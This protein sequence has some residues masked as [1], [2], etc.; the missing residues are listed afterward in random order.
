VKRLLGYAKHLPDFSW[1][2][3]VLTRE[4][5]G[6]HEAD[7]SWG[8]SWEPH[9]ERDGTCSI[10]RVPW[11]PPPPRPRRRRPA[12]AASLP[13]TAPP[14]DGTA[15]PADGTA[16]PADDAAPHA[17]FPAR[18]AAKLE[19]MR[20]M[21]FEGYPDGFTGWVGPAVEAGVRVA[22]EHGV[23]LIMSYCPPESNHLV[24]RR[25]A[26]RLGVPWVAFF[27]DLWGFL[28][29][30]LPAHSLEGLFR[31][32]WHRW[33]LAPA[34]ACAAVSPAMVD[35]LERAYS[36]PTRLIHTGFDPEEFPAQTTPAQPRDRLLISHVGSI[37]PGDQ[38]PD[39]LFDGLDRLLRAH[40]EIA[41][42]LEVR[43][44]GSKCDDRLRTLLAGRPAARVCTVRPGVDSASAIRLVRESH[45]LLAFTCTA[46][47]DRFGTLSFPTKIFEAFGARR[48]ILAI[49]PTA[50]GSM[51]C[52]RTPAATRAPATPPTSPLASSTGSPPGAATAAC[53]TTPIRTRSRST[54]A[55]ARSPTSPDS[56]IPCADPEPTE[57]ERSSPRMTGSHP[58]RPPQ[59]TPPTLALLRA[60]VHDD[61][62][63]IRAALADPATDL[64]AFL[65][66]AHRHQL[67]AFTAWSLHHLGL[68]RD[69]ESRAL[70]AVRACALS[71]RRTNERLLRML[72]DLA[73]IFDRGDARVL[74]IK[75]PLLAHRFYG[76]TDAR[77]ISDLDVLLRDPR[78]LDRVEAL[79][80]RNG[81]HPAFRVPGSRR[82][83]RIFA[84]HFE[85]RRDSLPLD[86]HWALQQ[87][88]T[89]NIDYARIAATAVA[90]GIDGRVYPTPSAEYELVL[91]ILGVLTDL[92]VGKL[93]LRSLVDIHRIIGTVGNSLDWEDFFAWRERERILRPAVWVIALA[94]EV[95]DCGEEFA[96]LRA[97]LAPRLRALPPPALARRAVLESRPLD[98]SQKLLAL[99]IYETPLAASLA[100]WAV[101]LPF[102]LAV[103]GIT[104]PRGA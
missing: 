104:R 16:S 32:R 75:G 14:A 88:I 89:F 80:L 6:T 3:L 74:F 52:S 45:A 85:Y 23:D 93:T 50:T 36:K 69:L 76:S 42:R 48:P 35:F 101:S 41:P 67:G 7:P 17:G 12:R 24:A 33:C 49:P 90:T 4:W 53:P 70:A 47:R 10:H 18:L 43:F 22:R 73:D 66:F 51:H 1:N 46:H 94:L 79:L 57:P 84:H 19:R 8:L 44:V 2:T 64:P 61:A 30:P 103:Y 5:H 98:P 56:S 72:R 60:L 15:P 100:W 71:E 97:L 63:R 21:L 29:P 11:R 38:R 87:H 86:V 27:G 91:Q 28:D 81:F 96:T 95:L 25:L 9:L 26:R 82:L 65:R 59:H 55:T 68:D 34:A 37:Y 31:R 62:A 83:A 78:D 77:G 99:R 40:P 102:R 54:P 92:Q 20:R 39:L 13:P 58:P